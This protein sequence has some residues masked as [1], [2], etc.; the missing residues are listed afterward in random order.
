MACDAMPV[1]QHLRAGS[2]VSCVSSIARRATLTQVFEGTF[3]ASEALRIYAAVVPICCV[4]AC[5]LHRLAGLPGTGP[6]R[7]FRSFYAWV[8]LVLSGRLVLVV[9]ALACGIAGRRW[10]SCPSSTAPT[11]RF[12]WCILSGPT[13]G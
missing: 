3:H 13:D 8:G 6:L 10:A 9:A 2:R 7:E 1:V 11:Q 12:R 5:E 4:G